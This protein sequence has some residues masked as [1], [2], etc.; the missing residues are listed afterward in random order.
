MKSLAFFLAVLT[1]AAGCVLEDKPVIPADGGVEAGP[2]GVCKLE[3]PI[4]NDDLQCVE[5]TAESN[6]LCLEKMLVCKTDAFECV[7]CN[8]S[9]D[10]NLEP[11]LVCKTD[12]FECVECNASSDCN[13]PAEAGCNTELNECEECQ[14]EADCTGIEGR[15]LCD[16]G[17]CVECTPATEGVDCGGTSCDPLTRECTKTMLGS[18]ETCEACVADSECGVEGS[19]SGD[20]R[21][22]EMFYPVGERF[23]D[24]DT[25]FCL[26]VFAPGVCE[27]PYAIRIPDRRSL[28]GDPLQSYCGIN[29]TLAT[30]P[31]VRA[32]DRNESCPCPESGI[33]RNVGGLSLKC[34]YHCEIEGVNAIEC[35]PDNPTGRPGTNCD[36]SGAGGAGGAYCGG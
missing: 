18:L 33:C 34:T 12:A 3:T 30:C 35:L 25:G 17:T 6:S 28:S 15:P 22:V 20:H 7:E 14:S 23:P 9:S 21:C 11:M 13:D 5:C 24:G 29:E 36:S 16:D 26:K 31:A 2:C 8:A 10:C 4:C 27:Q 19:P 1:L 32:L